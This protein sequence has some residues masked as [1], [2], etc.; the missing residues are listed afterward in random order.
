[1]KHVFPVQRGI[2]KAVRPFANRVS[3]VELPPDRYFAN[4]LELAGRVEGLDDLLTD[5]EV[6]GVRLVTNPERM[7]LRETQRAFL[8]FSL[9]GLVVDRVIVNR[10]L[11]G[12]V[13]DAYFAEWHRSQERVLAEIEEYFAPVPVR[14]VPLL[15]REVVGQA[16][17]EETARLLY[18]EEEDPAA[19][20]GLGRPYQFVK[21]NGRYL[22]RLQVPFAT[23]GEIGLF[24]KGDE[25]VVQVGTLRRHIGLPTSMARLEPGRAR[26]QGGI[27]TIEMQEAS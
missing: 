13:R 2:L 9:H 23:K 21:R 26:L 1:M 25:L 24:K 18:G 10:V 14:R 5:P 7:V 15:P 27:L 8:Y 17:L 3:P 4:V 6:T 11:P 12:E 16:R 19:P 20:S 22:V